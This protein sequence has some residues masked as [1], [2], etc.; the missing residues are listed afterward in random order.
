MCRLRI[1]GRF[2]NIT[3]INVHSPHSGSTDDDKDGFYTLVEREYNRCR[4]HDVK[5]IIGDLNSQLNASRK[6]FVPQAEICR[7]KDGSLLTDNRE[8]IDRWKQ[9]FD[10]H[11]NGEE[12]EQQRADQQQQHQHLPEQPGQQGEEQRG[13][14]QQQQG[15]QQQQQQLKQQQLPQEQNELPQQQNEQLQQQQLNEE[16]SRRQLQQV[17]QSRH[18]SRYQ[19]RYQP[20]YRQPE[21]ANDVPIVNNQIIFKPKH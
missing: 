12:N 21:H 16:Q 11:L 1:K 20:R 15:E 5:I 19:S 17:E 9:H 4:S 6:G 8:V 13:E 7:D 18:Q 14:Q 3:I 2:S 10:E